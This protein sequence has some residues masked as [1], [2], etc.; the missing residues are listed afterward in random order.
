MAM[1]AGKDVQCEKPTLTIDEGKI[2]VAEARRLK[3]VFQTS[4]EDRSVPVYHRMAELVRNGRIGKLQKIE[5][6]LPA[7]PTHPGKATPEP[8]PEHL[9]YDMWLGPAPDAPY[10]RERVHYNFR[11]IQDYSGGII[12]DW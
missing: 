4:T 7:H 6:V 1:R 8:V 9:D 11:W 3:K 10:T 5:V 2:L 12:C